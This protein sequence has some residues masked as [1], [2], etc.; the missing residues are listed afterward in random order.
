M[1]AAGIPNIGP[2]NIASFESSET[3]TPAG[4]DLVPLVDVSDS[5]RLKT[6]TVSSISSGATDA[7]VSVDAAATPDYLGAA[8]NDGALRAD[9]TLDYTDGGDYVTLGLD[10]TLKTNYDAASAHVSADGSSHSFIDQD[11]TNGAAPVLDATNFTNLPA[12]AD[13]KAAI[14]SGATADYVGAAAGDGFL[15]VD[16]SLDYADGGDFITISLDSTLK[17]NYDA[18]NAHI[19]ADGSSHADVG[20]NTTHRGLTN[21]P[22]TVTKAQVGLTNVTDNAQYYAGGADVAIADGGTGAGTAQAAIDALTAVAG[23]TNEH[24]LT[25]DTGTGNAVFKAAA[26][27]GGDL[28]AD[29]TVPLTANWDVGA[30]TITGTRFISDIAG[31]TAPFGV[32]STTVVSNLNVDQVDG[33]DSTDFVLVDG[34]QALTANW[35]VGAY[36]IKASSLVNKTQALSDGATVAVDLSAGTNMTLSTAGDRTMGEPS[37]IVAGDSGVFTITADG[38]DRT[39]T[40]HADYRFAGGGTTTLFFAST[41]NKVYWDSPDGTYLDC[42][43]KY[44]MA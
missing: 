18:A 37:N 3:I 31:G 23:A 14:D 17:S 21:N 9:A 36:Y 13:V 16:S 39:L 6:A 29:G 11:V 32:T 41:V 30:Y 34:T 7:K 38:T 1:A 24:V 12:D 26:A 40:W 2:A 10:S 4:T 33:K 19:S 27:S 44:G 43:V 22:H 35:D 5:N 42:T 28:K 15:R 8:T 20:T 25:K